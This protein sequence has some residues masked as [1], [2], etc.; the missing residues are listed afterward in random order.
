LEAVPGGA[1]L[2][3]R[4]LRSALDQKRVQFVVTRE[5]KAVREV[6]ESLDTVAIQVMA[7]RGVGGVGGSL[8]I[9]KK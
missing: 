3:L 2:L 4:D 1:A 6:G 5:G 9:K 7:I 8:T